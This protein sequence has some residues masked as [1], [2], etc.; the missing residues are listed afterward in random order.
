[1]GKENKFPFIYKT[2]PDGFFS[3]ESVGKFH[4]K[5]L[6]VL[7]PG[8]I[9]ITGKLPTAYRQNIGRTVISR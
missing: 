6:A 7:V 5:K 3:R 8:F 4:Q 2:I 9:S 1:M